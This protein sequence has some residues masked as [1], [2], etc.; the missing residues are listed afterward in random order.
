MQQG[1]SLP[2][3][4]R[5]GRDGLF[6]RIEVLRRILCCRR[7]FAVFGMPCGAG[8]AHIMP[9][10]IVFS[11]VVCEETPRLVDEGFDPIHH[12]APF[13]VSATKWIARNKELLLTYNRTFNFMQSYCNF[14]RWIMV[15]APENFSGAA[16][17]SCDARHYGQHF[18]SRIEPDIFDL[19]VTEFVPVE[20]GARSLFGR[21]E[22]NSTLVPNDLDFSVSACRVVSA[23]KVYEST[24]FWCRIFLCHRP[25]P[26]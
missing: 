2:S 6:A 19:F 20:L 9:F 17:R 24:E 12:T 22:R 21:N 1:K 15:A 16:S 10:R 25:S 13:P 14:N 23:G 8:A 26:V 5:S 18:A 11:R 4:S 7:R 3:L